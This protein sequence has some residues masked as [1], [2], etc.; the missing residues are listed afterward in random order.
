MGHAV[1]SYPQV[2]RVSGIVHWPRGFIYGIIKCGSVERLPLQR[3]MPGTV[4]WG[5]FAVQ[6]ASSGKGKKKSNKVSYLVWKRHLRGR[7]IILIDMQW[8][9]SWWSSDRVCATLY[10][11]K[12]DAWNES[13][14]L[15]IWWWLNC[16][17]I[18]ICISKKGKEFRRR[19]SIDKTRY[20]APT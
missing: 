20:F 6:S 12:R 8:T 10:S 19:H 4:S 14:F 9:V 11:V 16:I 5:R 17:C 1:L 7:I 2:E 15:V 13:R 3:L 18:C